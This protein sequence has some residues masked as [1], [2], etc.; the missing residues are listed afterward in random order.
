M[1]T[2]KFILRK[3]KGNSRGDAPIYAQYKHKDA[4][5]LIATGKK[6]DPKYWDSV[7]GKVKKHPNALALNGY[8]TKISNTINK[9][10]IDLQQ[11][12][13]EP[14]PKRIRDAYEQVL[15]KNLPKSILN[16]SVIYLWKDYVN[17]KRNTL[18][19]QSIK[20]LSNSINSLE[21]FLKSVRSEL[22][23]PEKFTLSHLIKWEDFL[24][25]NSKPNTVAKRLKDF[26]HF[27]TF[28]KALGGRIGLD[29][30]KISY[31]EK[32]GPKI[33][34]TE[35][36]LEAFSKASVTGQLEV[37]RDLFSLQC[38]TGLR[39]S[40]LKRIDKNIGEDRIIIDMQKTGKVIEIPINTP[41]RNILAKYNYNLPKVP[42]QKIN[43]GIKE[44]YRNLFPDQTIQV[45]D[46]GKFETIAKADVLSTH[47]AI[48]TFI[49]LS[50]ERGMPI[51]S[52][53]KITGK[54]M[55]VLIKHY[56]SESQKAADSEFTKAWG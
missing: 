44:I 55:Q 27:I 26:K 17:S 32:A 31:K 53:A 41:I 20:N 39:I 28:H 29:P 12:D 13:L 18:A 30:D 3:D 1:A 40:D 49:T 14:T 4:K 43:K 38:S 50:A 42:E 7:Q 11:A 45:R 24:N 36:E 22:I 46:K 2:V 56:L 19:K 16:G 15:S 54:S 34:L 6:I 52:I 21:N 9:I 33:Y 37:I 47:A 35:Q 48:R 5:T 25:A 8:F 51:T 23:T 10:V